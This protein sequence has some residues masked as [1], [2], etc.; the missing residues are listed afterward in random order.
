[1][2]VSAG[3]RLWD[4]KMIGLGT[5]AFFWQHSARAPQPLDLA[6]MLRQTHELNG[7]VFQICDYP[8]IQDY[9]GTN[10][11]LSGNWLASSVSCSN[12]EPRALP[13]PTSTA[14]CVWQKARESGWFRSMVNTPD[15][16]PGLSE[17]EQLLRTAMPAYESAG[18]SLALETYEQLS[19]SDLVTLVEVVGS[20]TGHLPRSGELRRGAGAS[21]GGD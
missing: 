4:N 15:H 9:S 21:Q 16:R 18:V 7:E 12:W 13:R 10:C 19:S 6:G 8:P 1:M 17:A 5:Y 20:L 2:K 14:I 11:V 3:K